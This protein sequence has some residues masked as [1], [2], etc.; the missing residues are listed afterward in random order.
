MNRHEEQSCDSSE[1]LIS[2]SIDEGL[3]RIAQRELLDHLVRCS[4]C[5]G[6]YAESRALEGLVAIAGEGSLEAPPVELWRQIED[7]T[8]GV[9]SRGLPGWA[10]RAAAAMLLGLA[11]AFVPWPVSSPPDGSVRQVNL[12]LEENRGDMTEGRFVDLATEILRSDRRYHFAMREVLDRV[13]DDEWELEGGTSE[14]LAEEGA[15]DEDEGESSPF[16]V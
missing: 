7:R 15:S 11:L 16:R 4:E 13:I 1:I 10:K 12:V 3:E 2:T 5:R 9:P 8:L 6:F 14:G